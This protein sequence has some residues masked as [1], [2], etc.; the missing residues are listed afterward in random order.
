ML[1]GCCCLKEKVCRNT[2]KLYYHCQS[3]TRLWAFHLSH[4]R[5]K[6]RRNFELRTPN[7]DIHDIRIVVEISNAESYR[8]SLISHR[9]L[10]NELR[11]S[12]RDDIT[13]QTAWISPRANNSNGNGTSWRTS[14][15][16]TLIARVQI[17]CLETVES[18]VRAVC[19]C[20]DNALVRSTEKVLFY[21]LIIFLQTFF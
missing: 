7:V 15:L 21:S 2:R 9:D 17:T 16:L 10:N 5:T 14:L 12:C 18:D 8:S 3:K 6:I 20:Y 13:F 4:V 11:T 1:F 19:S